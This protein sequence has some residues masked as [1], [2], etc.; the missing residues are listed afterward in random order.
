MTF[1]VDSSA[2]SCKWI[3]RG[4]CI[5]HKTQENEPVHGNYRL[6]YCKTEARLNFA[7]PITLVCVRLI[8]KLISY[9]I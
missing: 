8:I 2:D 6:S 7:Q 4:L 1:S 3:L 9:V 5:G